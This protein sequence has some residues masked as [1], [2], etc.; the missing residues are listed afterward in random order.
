MIM[1]IESEK[2]VQLFHLLAALEEKLE[3]KLPIDE[4]LYERTSMMVTNL[5]VFL[6]NNGCQEHC[7]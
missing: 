3:N 1:K 2:L 5:N 7:E 4:E 6:L